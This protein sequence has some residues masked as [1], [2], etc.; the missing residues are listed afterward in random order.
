LA[1]GPL[2]GIVSRSKNEIEGKT[3]SDSIRESDR[4]RVEAI[5]RKILEGESSETEQVFFERSLQ[6]YHLPIRDEK[7]EIIYGM[8]MVFDISDL[9]GTQ[10][11]LEKRAT[12]LQRSNEELERFAYV[13]SHDLQGPLRTIASY[14]QLLEMRY[15]DKLDT[16]ALEFID[17]SVN[18][19]KRMQQLIL[20]LLNYSRI[21]SLHKPF[22]ATS[23]EDIV[24]S[25]IK[26]LD[27]TIKATGAK[28]TYPNLH[29]VVGEPNHLY[30]LFQNLID[31]ALKF[32]KDKKPVIEIK[33]V[34]H[35][36][37]WEFSISDNGIGI[38][39]EYKEKIFQI[40]QRLHTV[41]EYPGTGVGLAI[42]KKVVQLHG[43]KIWFTSKPDEGT[44]FHFTIS[45]YLAPGK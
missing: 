25:V 31:N 19:A 22:T 11:E 12:Q 39:D 37:D 41:A 24:R 2:V 28:I 3:V 29:E 10:R 7:G 8:V 34:E 1:E 32:S 16:E 23:T 13:A 36:D 18:G 20:D 35:E 26:G 43:G 45:K 27:S 30:Q 33:S 44:T 38:K 17:F 5:Y 6:V 21:S 40:F 14:L 9:K 42:C 4:E 15:K